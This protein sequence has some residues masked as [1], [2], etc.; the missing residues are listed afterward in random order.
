V[1]V[2]YPGKL[3]I[4]FWP[5]VYLEVETF[6]Y[7]CG[8]YTSSGRKPMCVKNLI[9]VS[10]KYVYDFLIDRLLLVLFIWVTHRGD[11]IDSNQFKLHFCSDRSVFNMLTWL[12][13]P[14]TGLKDKHDEGQFFIA[15]ESSSVLKHLK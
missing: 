4:P 11:P 2:Q 3:A 8:I 13:V 12:R 7:A 5:P 1:A 9:H 15:C 14:T 6:A 10:S